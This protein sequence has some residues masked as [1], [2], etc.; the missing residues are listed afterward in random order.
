MGRF[1]TRWVRLLGGSVWL[2]VVGTAFAQEPEVDVAVQL[3]HGPGGMTITPKGSL[4]ISLH[5]Y[6]SLEDR[7]IEVTADGEIRPFPND[8]A[9]KGRAG[10]TFTLD[11]VQ[12]LECDDEGVVWM[13]D[14]GRR[15][16]LMPKIVAWDSKK[17]RLSKVIYLPQPATIPTSYLNDLALDPDSPMIYIS[18]PA[19]GNDAAMIVLNRE[20]GEARRV[21]Q[22]HY[23][24]IPE[25]IPLIVE[26]AEFLGKLSNGSTVEPQVGINPIAVDKK[27]HWVYYGPMK[28][29]TLF[30]IEAKHLRD[31]SLSGIELESRVKGYSEKP[32][33][34]GISIDS[35]G[36]IY[37][38]DLTSNAIGVIDKD[39]QRYRQYVDDP[40]FL[41]P[42][43]LCF[44]VDGRLHFFSCQIH[45]SAALN[46]GK[47]RTV[48][49][50]LV[51]KVKALA[52]GT[53]GR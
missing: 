16:E 17:D 46:R 52:S 53:V 35:K 28:G 45:R 47:D 39:D 22:G 13:L 15:G 40:R 19:A 33:S 3:S 21:F 5:Q 27:G 51:F 11:S 8:V 1:F 18:D 31:G 23:S 10:G 2:A 14:N 38:A 50:F 43:G 25:D 36:N 6:F 44:G 49:P 34:D 20:T 30:R 9:G 7:V 42:D 26:G 29:R 12:G 4:I 32:I 48:A 41:W 37:V 24:V